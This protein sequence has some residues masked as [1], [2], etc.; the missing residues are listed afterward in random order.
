[1]KELYSTEGV[2][3]VSLHDYDIGPELCPSDYK[4]TDIWFMY[5]LHCL[6]CGHKAV[7]IKAID[8]ANFRALNLLC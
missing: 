5:A 1:M 4:G 6:P 3:V 8:T 7:L 2:N